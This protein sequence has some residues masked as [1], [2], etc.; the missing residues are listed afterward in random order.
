MRIPRS[1]G[2]AK[3]FNLPLLCNKGAQPGCA[4]LPS[5]CSTIS[6]SSVAHRLVSNFPLPKMLPHMHQVSSDLDAFSLR[7]MVFL[8]HLSHGSPSSL[9][10]NKREQNCLPLSQY[11]RGPPVLLLEMALF[12]LLMPPLD[13][14]LWQ[15]CVFAMQTPHHCGMSPTLWPEH[16]GTTAAAAAPHGAA[17]ADAITTILLWQHV[18]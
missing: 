7:A 18:C 1:M 2:K 6:T 17:L 14:L 3:A 9:T 13:S 10:E 16:R 5:S 11:P 8:T 4:E 15:P 12:P